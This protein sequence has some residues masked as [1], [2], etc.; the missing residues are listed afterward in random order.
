MGITEPEH[1][2]QHFASAF[3]S[4]DLDAVIKLYEPD[5]ALVPQPGQVTKG[6]SANRQA[7]QQFMA[8]RGR[9]DIKTVY[10]IRAGDLALLRG[11]WRLIG[12]GPDGKPVEMNGKNV[13]VACRQPN[14]D[15]L[16]AIDHPYGA[17]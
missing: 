8:L 1:L 2:H 16:F 12:T 5:A 4:G 14:G 10:V 11:E 13:E 3:N 17:T 7:L 6:L 9:I 15:W